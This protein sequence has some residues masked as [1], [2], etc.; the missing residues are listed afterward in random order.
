MVNIPSMSY[1][2]RSRWKAMEIKVGDPDEKVKA[3]LGE[4]DVVFGKVDD[5]GR[6]SPVDAYGFRHPGKHDTDWLWDGPRGRINDD[7][8]RTSTPLP[9]V[10]DRAF[11]YSLPWEG[12]VLIYI[13]DGVV[14]AVFHGAT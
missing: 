5:I 6:L 12:C 14:T 4:P 10:S 11:F 9:A 2:L 3:L 8:T 7:D 13:E 1:M